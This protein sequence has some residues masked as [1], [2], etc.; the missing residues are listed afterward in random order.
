MKND[1]YSIFMHW[2]TGH[3]HFELSHVKGVGGS[4][5][6]GDRWKGRGDWHRACFT[7]G[8]VHQVHHSS[9]PSKMTTNIWR[10]KVMLQIIKVTKF[11]FTL[12]SITLPFHL[13]LHYSQLE[14]DLE[15]MYLPPDLSPPPFPG[16]SQHN[17][18][19]TSYENDNN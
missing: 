7:G 18:A 1:C 3:L 9:G 17:R 2:L 5:A 19:E 13:L 12:T 11:S 4:G 10:P 16:T 6:R 15:Q 14:Q 8:I